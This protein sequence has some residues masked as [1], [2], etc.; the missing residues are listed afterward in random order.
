VDVVLEPISPE[1]VLVCAELRDRLLAMLTEPQEP[2][3][4][5]P[6]PQEPPRRAPRPRSPMDPVEVRFTVPLVVAVAAAVVARLSWI[7]FMGLLV[8]TALVA[9]LSLAVR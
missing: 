1:L 2:A 5:A 9:V 3:S 7:V 6:P 4:P 8:V